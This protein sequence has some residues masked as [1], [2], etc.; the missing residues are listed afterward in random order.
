MRSNCRQQEFHVVAT[1]VK[2]RRKKNNSK[3]HA[4][5]KKKIITRNHFC[6]CSNL[7]LS[8]RLS[9]FSFLFFVCVCLSFAIAFSLGLIICDFFNPVAKY[10]VHIK[11]SPCDL[12]GKWNGQTNKSLIIFKMRRND[13]VGRRPLY[14]YRNYCCWHVDLFLY[15]VHSRQS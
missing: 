3:S 6:I 9:L 7:H 5:W 13:C 10:Y 4:R 2:L 8:A 14:K 12:N 1:V 15:R 11:L